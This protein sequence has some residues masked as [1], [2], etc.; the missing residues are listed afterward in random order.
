MHLVGFTTEIY[1]DARPYERQIRVQL[2]THTLSLNTICCIYSELPP[3]DE[4][5]IYSKHVEDDY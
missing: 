2:L 1:Y 5:L 3:D 4:W